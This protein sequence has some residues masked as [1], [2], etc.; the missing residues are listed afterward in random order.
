[1]AI[2]LVRKPSE[3]PNVANYADYRM[4]R[5]A[6]GGYNGV[7]EKHGNECGYEINGQDFKVK[8]GEIVIDGVQAK[9]DGAGSIITTD[10]VSGKEYYSVFC[11]IDLSIIDNQRVFIKAMKSTVSFPVISKGDDLTQNQSGV[12]RLLLYTFEVNNNVISNVLKKFSLISLGKAKNAESDEDGN[13]I[14][15]TYVKS[16]KFENNARAQFGNFYVPKRKLLWSGEV[17]M[18]GGELTQIDFQQNLGPNDIIEIHFKVLDLENIP[19]EDDVEYL[20]P[21]KY[22][23][24][25]RVYY[26][27]LGRMYYC[28]WSMNAFTNGIFAMMEAQGVELSIPATGNVTVVNRNKPTVRVFAVYRIVA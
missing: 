22:R 2:E 26:N 10:S 12:A 18:V 16:V 21:Q 6:T 14:K 13:K 7:V 23:E 25:S 20:T 24:V 15:D 5:Y 11:E 1:M 9:I 3:T 27:Y 8:S 4:F 19:N 17:T 28:S